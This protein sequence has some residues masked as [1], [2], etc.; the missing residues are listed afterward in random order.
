MR[1]FAKRE[2]GTQRVLRL[3]PPIRR[4]KTTSNVGELGCAAR[5]R[6]R[7]YTFNTKISILSQGNI[8]V[9]ENRGERGGARKYE[10]IFGGHSGERCQ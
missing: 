2:S 7:G 6:E 3:A 1:I 8:H 4:E 10:I 9:V 5:S